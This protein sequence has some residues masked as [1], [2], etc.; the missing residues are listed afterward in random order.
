MHLVAG[1]DLI[2]V[3]CLKGVTTCDM[4]RD[5]LLLRILYGSLESDLLEVE[6]DMGYIFQYPWNS[7][8]FMLYTF[9]TDRSYC[10]PL[11]L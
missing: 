4:E 11:Y 5:R 10:I 8:K 7:S 3:T 2:E 6:Y 1:Q 9:D